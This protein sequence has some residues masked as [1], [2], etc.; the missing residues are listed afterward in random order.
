MKDVFTSYLAQMI[1]LAANFLG[2]VLM[3]RLLLPVG[4]GELGQIM[5]WPT[6]IASLGAFAITD[7]IIYFGASRPQ[8]MRRVIASAFAIGAVLSVVLMAAGAVALGYL[9]AGE[10]AEVRQTADVYLLIIPLSF[11]SSYVVAAFQADRRFDLW[12]LLRVLLS[13]AYALFAVLIWIT[14]DATVSAFAA[15]SLLANLI[16]YVTGAVLLHRAGE[17]GVRP[18]AGLMKEMLGYGFRIHIANLLALANQRLDQILV[19]RWFPAA[20]FGY[21]LIAVTVYGS[22]SGLVTLLGSLVFP[23]VAAAESTAARAQALGRYLR[24]AAALSI[25][26]GALLF[27]LAPW[28]ITAIYGK[29]YHPAVASVQVF[30]IGIAPTAC[31][32]LLGA[33]F[34]AVGKTRT[35]IASELAA[36]I[37][38]AIGLVALIPYFGITGAAA[39]CSLAQT[40]A[41][42]V[43]AIAVPRQLDMTLLSLFAPTSADLSRVASLFK[44]VLGAR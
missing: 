14:D 29:A 13:S 16:V 19:N 10:R 21:Y 12:N 7:A 32:S 4:R 35:I 9:N 5:L 25:G 41:F 44:D 27:V 22:A 8:D 40:G 38:C 24:L 36:L 15:A 39:A 11:A 1:G 30:A 31:K 3:A 6:L 43:L 37:L 28:L 33:A 26:G 23:K 2:G 17:F 34:K 20:E 18:R 42:V